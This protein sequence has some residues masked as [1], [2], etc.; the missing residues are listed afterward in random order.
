TGDTG[1]TGDTGPTGSTGVTGDTGPT[2]S[3]GVT[4]ATGATGATGPEISQPYI[5]LNVDL[6]DPGETLMLTTN[7]KI[8]F[9]TTM[10]S[11]YSNRNLTYNNADR[12]VQISQTG[13]YY[14]DFSVHCTT[15]NATFGLFI[16]DTLS[17]LRSPTPNVTMGNIASSR[18]FLYNTGDRIAVA[19]VSAGTVVITNSSEVGYSAAHLSI[20]RI[21]S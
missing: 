19:N 21:S 13:L 5:N 2:G 18:I 10:I 17:P 1:A 6:G 8:P 3:T 11:G 16:N 15:A 7:Q 12:N 20:V 4:G 9:A 14:V